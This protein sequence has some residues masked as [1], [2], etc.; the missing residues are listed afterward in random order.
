MAKVGRP[1]KFKSVEELEERV[2]SYFNE[3]LPTKTKYTAKGKP[4][5]I[6][7]PTV[8]GLALHL[9]FVDRRSFYDYEDKPEFTHAIKRARFLIEKHYEELAQEGVSTAIFA[10]KN[11]GWSDA[12][13]VDLT[14]KGEKIGPPVTWAKPE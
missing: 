5:Y 3:D 4:Y 8:A 7:V 13:S 9:G 14:S 11:F 10:L 12:S 2:R 6:Q 1:P